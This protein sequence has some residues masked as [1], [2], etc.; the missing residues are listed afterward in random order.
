MSTQTVF[1]NG[2]A[3]QLGPRIGRGGEGDVFLVTGNQ[4]IA[5][6][7]YT[8]QNL[9]DRP[10]KIRAMVQDD[11][12][13][14]NKVVAYPLA[15]VRDKNGKFLG[16]SMR[17]MEGHRQLHDLYAPG[18]RK[19]H[20]PQA[21][22]R[23]LVRTANNVARAVAEV[24]KQSCVIG[25]INHSSILISPKA[26]VGLIDA[27]SFQARTQV[28][29]HLCKVGV[30]EYTPPELQ[31]QSFAGRERT[32]N[33]D[34]FG[35]AV[36]IF[37]LLFMGRHPFV[38]IPRRGDIPPIPDSIREFRYAYSD[39][40]N[41]GV[42]QPPGTPSI[43]D[44]HPPL[45]Q[46]FD[47][48][49][50]R[51]SSSARPTAI[52]WMQTLEALEQSLEACSENSL[53]YIPKG[54]PTCPWCDMEQQLGTVLFLPHVPAAMMAAGSDPGPVNFDLDGIWVLIVRVKST[55]KL[56][57]TPKLPVTDP[58]VSEQAR[59]AK[60]ANNFGNPLGLGLIGAAVFAMAT[61]PKAIVIWIVMLIAGF[62][63]LWSKPELNPT[64]FVTSYIACEQ[65]FSR[66]VESWASRNGVNE[67]QKLFGELESARDDYALLR[68]EE[69]RKIAALSTSRRD[70]QLNAYLNG[71]AIEDTKLKGIGEGRRTVL[72]SFGIN[73]A[74]DISEHR[75]LR[76]PGF[77]HATSHSM[78]EWRKKLEQRFV[79]RA[80]MTAADFQAI[81]Q[82]RAETEKKLSP[83]RTKLTAG[84]ENLSRLV[85][86]MQK[87][88]SNEDPMLAKAA[89][90][91]DEAKADLVHLG[92]PIPIVPPHSQYRT[93]SAR[94]YQA[95]IQASYP[96]AAQQ[97]SSPQ[98]PKVPSSP[99]S[100][101]SVTCPRCG[102]P[103]V[104]RMARKGK[105]AGSYFWGCGRYPKCNGTRNI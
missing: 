68:K 95:P 33:H 20:F 83:L 18:P 50:L 81:A 22:Y 91:R 85:Q 4:T 62:R 100:S 29:L 23:F 58:K 43:A 84:P 101:A 80:D 7:I 31:G 35:L 32:V 49:F 75:L 6:K 94:S 8:L 88:A 67:F 21:D 47:R 15:E 61:L 73:T 51:T 59:E 3:H 5:I 38:G 24:H 17:L 97:P 76:I 10:Q 70:A 72:S 12:A 28:G 45:A 34:A 92:I 36:V 78:L 16:F 57:L 74:A 1:I 42:D 63:T 13:G 41:F 90:K 54:A 30:P 52:E 40:E 56:Q 39:A 79:Y 71:Y 26:T 96:S 69:E 46:A 60:G 82:I 19:T 65:L 25:D 14:A 99:Q 2:L 9:D 102:Q 53:H 55:M 105:N 89:L 98:S 48:A 64:P 103:M 86:R 104:R 37:Q 27:D 11:L 44:F 77:G 87:I 66:E 93:P